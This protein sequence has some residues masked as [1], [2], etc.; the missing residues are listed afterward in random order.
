MIQKYDRARFREKFRRYR[1][2]FFLFA[3]VFFAAFVAELFLYGNF[4]YG[5]KLEGAPFFPFF[6]ELFAGEILLLLAL[7]LFGVTLYAPAFGF[8]CAVLRGGFSAFCLSVLYAGLNEKSSF[9]LFL[10]TALYLLLSA[11][12]FLS[13]ASFCTTTALQ[14]YS[15][16]KKMREGE[17]QAFGGSLF[18]STFFRGSVNL[19]FLSSYFLLLLSAV[20]CSFLM[21]LSF[22]AVRSIL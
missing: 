8:L 14:I 12:L 20:F 2:F 18:Y 9:L 22:A 4:N 3:A 7:F 21:T 16:P 13:Y 10:L 1:L 6:S 17:K 19:R 5:Y 15:V 11:W